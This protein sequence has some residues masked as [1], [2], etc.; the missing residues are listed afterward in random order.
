MVG[1]MSGALATNLTHGFSL[2]ECAPLI[3]MLLLLAVS[4]WFRNPELTS[5]LLGK[6]VPGKA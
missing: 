3:V 2:A 4:G 6:P 1:Y 5:R